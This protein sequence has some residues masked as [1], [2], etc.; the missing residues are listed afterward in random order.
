[1]SLLGAA[2]DA[3]NVAVQP[4]GG[5]P[6]PGGAPS[7]STTSP[8]HVSIPVKLVLV[9]LVAFSVLCWIVIFAKALHLAR[10]RGDSDKFMKAF[11]RRRL[12][13]RARAARALG[14]PR[15]A[16]RADLRDRLRR[17]GPAHQRGPGAAPRRRSGDP[18]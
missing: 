1:M 14:L 18:C 6:A 16:L 8:P 3:I 9:I 4:A 15:L 11:R 12:A 2:T 10:A 17:D 13:R 7:A 5:A